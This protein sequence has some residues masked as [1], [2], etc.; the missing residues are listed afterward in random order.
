M[1]VVGFVLSYSIEGLLIDKLRLHVFVELCRGV[2]ILSA[3]ECGLLGMSSCVVLTV[4]EK[5]SIV[6]FVYLVR[7]C[8][9][10]HRDAKFQSASVREDDFVQ[11]VA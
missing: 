10:F 3:S 6:E 7:S 1:R 5:V 11:L 8:V 9:D 4:L 2:E